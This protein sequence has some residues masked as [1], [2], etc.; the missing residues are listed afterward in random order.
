MERAWSDS[1]R[2]LTGIDLLNLRAVSGQGAR[3]GS[4]EV[5]VLFHAT[6]VNS[7]ESEA[8]LETWQQLT[9]PLT[10]FAQTATINCDDYAADCRAL[11]VAHFPQAALVAGGELLFYMGPMTA[12]ALFLFVTNNIYS[13][14]YQLSAKKIDWWLEFEVEQNRRPVL[15]MHDK[16]HLPA[17]LAGIARSLSSSHAFAELRLVPEA[18]R[19]RF[20]VERLPALV[21]GESNQGPFMLFQGE[22]KRGPLRA[23]LTGRDSAQAQV[24]KD[25]DEIAPSEDYG[26]L[27]LGAESK[28]GTVCSEG[29]TIFIIPHG[30]DAATLKERRR[31]MTAANDIMRAMRTGKRK[32]SIS[33]PVWASTA[34]V[35][36]IDAFRQCGAGAEVSM[37]VWKVKRN[38]AAV[39]NDALTVESGTRFLDEI[40]AGN[41]NFRTL[42]VPADSLLG[43]ARPTSAQQGLVPPDHL[44]WLYPSNVL[45]EMQGAIPPQPPLTLS[46]DAGDGETSLLL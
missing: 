36:V 31:R 11:Q 14:V 13:P 41:G 5:L 30:K 32:Q 7:Q 2:K 16:P 6:P 27:Q 1:C 46:S 26:M 9:G 42:P 3:D 24:I 18:V 15:L 20:R 35:D 34:Q 40:L 33:E 37:A 21:M 39:L 12:K 43:G 44:D 10:G 8:A 17:A 23:F 38:R 28:E 45:Q 29:C 4:D 19:E 25:D 22:F